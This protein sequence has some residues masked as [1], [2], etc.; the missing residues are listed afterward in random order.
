V[1]IVNSAIF[2]AIVTGYGALCVWIPSGA[3]RPR[4][5]MLGVVAGLAVLG[6]FVQRSLGEEDAEEED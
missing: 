6:V 2:G 5:W 1:L 4:A 3:V